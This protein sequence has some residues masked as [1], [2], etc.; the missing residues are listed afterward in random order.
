MA[1]SRSYPLTADV[2]VRVA[3]TLIQAA[4][5]QRPVVRLD[6]GVTLV[7]SGTGE[8]AELTLDG[9]LISGGDIVLRGRFGSVTLT[10]CT[11]DPG[12]AAAPAAPAAAGPQARL[13]PRLLRRSR[14]RRTAGR[15]RRSGSGSRPTRSRRRAR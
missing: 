9:L 8:S 4:A 13:A 5:L 3:S 15:W 2:T 11:L 12:T 6:P 1:D 14:P 7:F 10:G